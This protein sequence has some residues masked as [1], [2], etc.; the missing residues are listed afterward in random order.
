MFGLPVVNKRTDD[1]WYYCVDG[2]HR[3]A[4]VKSWLGAEWEKQSVTCRLYEGMT[5][6]EEAKMFLILN[7]TLTVSSFSKFL[8]GVTAGDKV[9]CAIKK[10]TE[11]GGLSITREKIPGALSAVA[12]LVRVYNRAD[13]PTLARCLHISHDAFG[14][15]GLVTPVI[16]GIARVCERY[17]GTIDDATAISRL[18]SMRG[19]V[20]ALLARAEL[21]RQQLGKPLADC[22][23]AATIEALNARRGGRGGK[24]P[25]YW[26][27]P[28]TKENPQ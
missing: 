16:D 9:A 15:P 10:I 26:H 2:Q 13:G 18:S 6:K 7:D 19:G 4:A 24:L 11:A 12:T 1:T 5:E 28:A 3:I 25:S 17:N 8:V 27:E 20:G 23:A 22:V 21:V 14:D